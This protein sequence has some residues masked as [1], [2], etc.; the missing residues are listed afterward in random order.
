MTNGWREKHIHV[1][2]HCATRNMQY[3]AW[4]LEVGEGGGRGAMLEVGGGQEGHVPHYYDTARLSAKLSL[5]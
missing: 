1:D 4:A 3:R 5:P 2:I